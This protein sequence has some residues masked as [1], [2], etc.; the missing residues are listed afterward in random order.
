MGTGAL[1]SLGAVLA[2]AAVVLARHWPVLLA[3]SLAAF[4]ARTWVMVAAVRASAVNGVLGYLVIV[5]APLGTLVALVVMLRVAQASLPAVR[6]AVVDWKAGALLNHLGSVLVPFLVVYAYTGYLRDDMS[7]YT[8]AVWRAEISDDLSFTDPGR[9]DVM[10]RLPFRIT[11]GLL[12]IIG[13]AAL[14]RFALGRWG[15]RRWLGIFGAYLEVIWLT[16]AAAILF[17]WFLD[18][19]TGRRVVRWMGDT[20]DGAL[21]R[22]GSLAG[23]AQ[24]V[25]G[26]LYDLIADA[27]AIIAVPIAWLTV[28]AVVYGYRLA[29]PDRPT[30]RRSF[31]GAIGA[32][33]RERFGPL[34]D[35]LRLL[36]GGG[37][38]RMLLFCLLF[39]VVQSTSVWL[40]QLERL[41]VGPRD[42]FR[43]WA[44]LSVPLSVINDAIQLT[45]L[46]CLLAAAVDQVL[47]LTQAP[48]VERTEAAV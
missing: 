21:D 47:R 24:A 25:Q 1:R 35:G 40:W 8:Y 22:L 14:L 48:A 20:T 4:A 33:L 15:R 3:L 46:A 27:T 38:R 9:V 11:G 41:I 39:V 30:G 32:S 6:D 23:A 44:P 16:A 17:N 5:L 29:P 42:L 31:L 12:A 28:G 10:S 34:V 19:L 37:V 7:E 2:R 36:T 18:W 13:V 45:L 43:F 26:W